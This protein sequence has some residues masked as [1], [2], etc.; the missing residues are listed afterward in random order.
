MQLRSMTGAGEVIDTDRMVR[1]AIKWLTSE[2]VLVTS[3]TE[4]DGSF[5]RG[6]EGRRGKS[7]G[8][9][10]EITGYA[11]SLFTYLYQITTEKRF[12]DIA[13][14]AARF[15]L[16]VQAPAGGY[17]DW[18]DHP[19]DENRKKL[20]AF[21]TAMCMVGLLRLDGCTGFTEFAE[22]AR[23]AGEWLLKMQRPDGSFAAMVGEDVGAVNPG[24]F[25]SDGSC[26]HAKNSLALLELY[27]KTGRTQFREAAIRAC[28]YAMGLQASDGAFWA[29]PKRDYVFTHAHCYAC[30][31]LLY[32]GQV[33]EEPRFVRAAEKGIEW[34]ASVQEAD[35]GW[36]SS[37][38]QALFTRHRLATLVRSPRASDASAQAARLFRLMGDRYLAPYQSAVAFLHRSQASDGGWYYLKTRSGYSSFVCTWATQFAIQ[39]LTWNTLPASVEDLF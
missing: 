19:H 22:G 8:I 6:V 27:R 14:R 39:A 17:Y 21:D 13:T 5:L 12:L 37:Y 31:G 1:A 26:I 34:L 7:L 15:L 36:R 9:Y 25:F 32:T 11:V 35:G 20:Y 29:V 30:E 2:P 23:T 28:D 3:E 38:K 18:S 4:T 24:H 16:A 33:A 10:T